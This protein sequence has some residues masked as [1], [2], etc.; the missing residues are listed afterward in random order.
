MRVIIVLPVPV[1]QSVQSWHNMDHSKA[2]SSWL[3]C[4]RWSE[5]TADRAAA[6]VSVTTPEKYSYS[7][8]G[9][10]DRKWV[11]GPEFGHG[12]EDEPPPPVEAASSEDEDVESGEDE[13]GGDPPWTEWWVRRQSRLEKGWLWWHGAEEFIIFH[14]RSQFRG[15]RSN[16]VTN[17]VEEIYFESLPTGLQSPSS[18]NYYFYYGIDSRYY[19]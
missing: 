17:N 5:I 2:R 6:A 15:S 13:V 14:G 9:G 19:Y 4:E 16:D 12:R 10:R 1:Q 18:C 7:R 8:I 3:A 11:S